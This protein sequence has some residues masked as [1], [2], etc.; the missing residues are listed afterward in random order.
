MT[1]VTAPDL[2]TLADLEA[3]AGLDLGPEYVLP[4]T[5]PRMYQQ[6]RDRLTRPGYWELLTVADYE[7]GSRAP[8]ER[9]LDAP[10][11]I[12]VGQL[13]AW[14]AGLLGHPVALEADAVEL[15]ADGFLGRWHPEPLY[16]VRRDT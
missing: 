15:K 5:P 2:L 10:R 6:V 1:I 9:I 8:E 16:W 4:F 3:L 14:A 11:D 13:A 12:P 7:A